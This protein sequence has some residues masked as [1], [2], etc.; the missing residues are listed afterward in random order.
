M[1]MITNRSDRHRETK[2]TEPG[3]HMTDT[4]STRT[5]DVTGGTATRM[6][7]RYVAREQRRSLRGFGPDASVSGLVTA[8]VGAADVSRRHRERAN[9]F[10]DD[11]GYPRRADS[12]AEP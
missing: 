1:V 7:R 5:R 12:G 2:R 8:G 11:D 3:F 6:A 9:R 4:D 10:G